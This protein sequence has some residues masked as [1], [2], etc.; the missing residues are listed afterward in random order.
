MYLHSS[1]FLITFVFAG[2]VNALTTPFG[3][4]RNILFVGDSQCWALGNGGFKKLL[5][6]RYVM[7]SMILVG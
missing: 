2:I 7:L 6:D 5:A 4:S 3:V 1:L